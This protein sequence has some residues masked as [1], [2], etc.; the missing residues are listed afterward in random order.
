MANKSNDNK[1]LTEDQKAKQAKAKAEAEEKARDNKIKKCF[2][3]PASELGFK[4]RKFFA[5]GYGR[6]VLI[7]DAEID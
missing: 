6:V 3:K 2:V 5:P 7:A 1:N 4:K